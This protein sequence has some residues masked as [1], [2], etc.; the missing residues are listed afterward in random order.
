[1][2]FGVFSIDSGFNINFEL[3]Q[4]THHQ[5]I[6]NRDPLEPAGVILLRVLH[7]FMVNMVHSIEIR[8]IF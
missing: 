3:L 1:M 5:V 8:V 6:H 4:L 7:V 2:I